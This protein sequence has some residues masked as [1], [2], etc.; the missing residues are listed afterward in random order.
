M[1]TISRAAGR[2]PSAMSSSITG[3]PDDGGDLSQPT[4][5]SPE[6]MVALC[7]ASAGSPP[8]DAKADKASSKR[9]KRTSHSV[10]CWGYEISRNPNACERLVVSIN[11]GAF[12]EHFCSA[13]R[14][15]GVHIE[16]SR[17]YMAPRERSLKNAHT[18]GAW[19]ECTQNL[20]LPPWPPWRVVNQTSDCS[21]PPLVVLRDEALGA[22]PGLVPLSPI[23]G[24]VAG[25]VLVEFRVG[26]TLTPVLPLPATAFVPAQAAVARPPPDS[27]AFANALVLEPALPVP[28]AQGARA[29]TGWP[30]NDFVDALSLEIG[31]MA[32]LRSFFEVDP[33]HAGGGGGGAPP[34]A[35]PPPHDAYTGRE[36]FAPPTHAAPGCP[37]S[38]LARASSGWLYDASLS[39]TPSPQLYSA[40]PSP[41]P[42]PSDGLDPPAGSAAAQAGDW[43]IPGIMIRQVWLCLSTALAT[44][45]LARW[46]DVV[47]RGEVSAVR[48]ALTINIVAILALSAAYAALHFAGRKRAASAAIC[49]GTLALEG[50]RTGSVL[51]LS[52]HDVVF[53]VGQLERRWRIRSLANLGHGAIL[54]SDPMPR[55]RLCRLLAATLLLKAARYGLVYHQTALIKAPASEVLAFLLGTLLALPGSRVPRIGSVSSLLAGS[56]AGAAKT[57][58]RAQSTPFQVS[59]AVLAALATLAIQL[60]LYHDEINPAIATVT[61]GMAGIAFSHLKF[62][63]PFTAAAVATLCTAAASAFLVGSLCRT[64]AQLK[65]DLDAISDGWLFTAFASA[66]LGARPRRVQRRRAVARIAAP[67]A[68]E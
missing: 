40:P 49:A 39:D 48:W 1:T 11:G 13:C 32:A 10:V 64:S 22:L 8:I 5:L 46:S 38:Q 53:V 33:R 62:G 65:H 35:C 41:P 37:S 2:C 6:S 44:A 26:R 34:H 63:P 7:G 28:P 47:A 29:V 66:S 52:A 18:T 60:T 21:G 50:I 23:A 16:S 12:R 9:R 67:S 61:L 25:T 4:A 17:I 68:S 51:A 15:G 20:T 54:G 36:M 27:P 19:N 30:L 56:K 58:R 3:S 14:S 42:P 55:G 45:Q 59:L 43:T 24:A 31:E 57:A